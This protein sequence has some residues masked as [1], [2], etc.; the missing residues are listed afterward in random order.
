MTLETD[1]DMSSTATSL[2]WAQLLRLG[3]CSA[4]LA[5]LAYCAWRHHQQQASF[6]EM[7]RGFLSS[8][9]AAAKRTVRDTL[10]NIDTGFEELISTLKEKYVSEEAQEMLD[11]IQQL[12]GRFKSNFLNRCNI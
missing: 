4:S 5:A 9:R 7:V 6:L 10:D 1:R 3:V 8:T 2:N 12:V 11:N